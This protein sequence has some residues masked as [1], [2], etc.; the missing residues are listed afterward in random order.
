MPLHMNVGVVLLW[1]YL[2]IPC[3]DMKSNLMSCCVT[4]LCVMIFHGHKQSTLCCRIWLGSFKHK[5]ELGQYLTG[6][7]TW[8]ITFICLHPAVMDSNLHH[9]SVLRVW[10]ELIAQTMESGSQFGDIS[11][12]LLFVIRIQIKFILYCIV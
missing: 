3:R 1:F 8:S 6:P 9:I 12:Y 10:W 7:H 11:I 5:K 2:R 4:V